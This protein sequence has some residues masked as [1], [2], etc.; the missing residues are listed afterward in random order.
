[1]PEMT[2]KSLIICDEVRQENNGKYFLIGVYGEDIRFT[3]LPAQIGISLF[4]LFDQHSEGTI[5]FEYRAITSADESQELFH[6]SG[7]ANV[8]RRS[9]NAPFA[10]GPLPVLVGSEGDLIVQY[11]E[12]DDAWSEV[13]RLPIRRTQPTPSSSNAPSQP[14]SQSPHDIPAK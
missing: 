3:R 12:S 9:S 6:F 13:A 5:S 1:M 7:Q 8:R 10:V 11:R 14:A 2:V 4:C